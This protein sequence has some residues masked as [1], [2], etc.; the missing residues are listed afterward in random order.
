M[1]ADSIVVGGRRTS[2]VLLDHSRLIDFI[3]RQLADWRRHGDRRA[4]AAEVRL[5]A[6]LCAFL[7]MRASLDF[8]VVSFQTE[9]PDELKGNRSF[10]IAVVPRRPRVTVSGRGY[11]LYD[12]ILPIECKRMPTPVGPDRQ[13][14][15][16][17]YTMQGVGGGIQR[18]KVAVHGARHSIAALIGYVQ[19]DVDFEQWRNAINTWIGGAPEATGIVRSETLGPMSVCDEEGITCRASSSHSRDSLSDITIHHLWVAMNDSEG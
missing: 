19:D 8:D 5:N 16:Y 2:S 17:V 14:E 10:D 15:E 1:L 18:Y 3:L 4:V 11:S 12:A 6:Q 13:R 7:N 9:F